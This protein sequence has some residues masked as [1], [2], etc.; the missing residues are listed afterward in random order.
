MC[1]DGWL[2]FSL[3]YIDFSASTPKAK[4]IQ[5]D[6]P[7]TI[8]RFARK[9]LKAMNSM[10]THGKLTLVNGT[11]NYR[12]HIIWMEMVASNFFLQCTTIM[13]QQSFVPIGTLPSLETQ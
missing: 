11:V 8:T 12:V 10:M 5:Q 4:T 2:Q 9:L 1:S 6:R 7:N 3:T 13:V